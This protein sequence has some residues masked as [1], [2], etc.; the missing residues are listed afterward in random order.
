MS[1][2]V[3]LSDYNALGRGGGNLG[4]EAGNLRGQLQ[5]LVSELA[6]SRDAMEGNQVRAFDR[7]KN[8][9]FN[10]FDELTAWCNRHG[11]KLGDSQV[12]VNQ[13]DQSNEGGFTGAG[14]DIGGL[15]RPIN[16]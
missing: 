16:A 7:A 1:N 15:T 2:Y 3:G 9:L 8:E 6:Q 5:N 12:V 13:T 10:R 14:N 4:Q 11:V